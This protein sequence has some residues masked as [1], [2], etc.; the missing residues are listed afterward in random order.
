MLAAHSL[1]QLT[2]HIPPTEQLKQTFDRVVVERV[3]FN[4]LVNQIARWCNTYPS[5]VQ[6][7]DIEMMLGAL[8]LKF[9]EHDRQVMSLLKAAVTPTPECQHKNGEGS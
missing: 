7:M 2:L 3:R 1:D 4:S 9:E 5:A 8:T 6:R